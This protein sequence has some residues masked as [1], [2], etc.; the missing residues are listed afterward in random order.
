MR[1][2]R[3]ILVT[4][5]RFLGDIVLSTPLLDALRAAFPAA[6][7]EYLGCPPHV[8][9]LERHPSVDRIHRLAADADPAAMLSMARALRAGR[10]DVAID[11]FGNP[12]SALLVAATGASV[13]VGPERGLRSYL[14]THRRGRPAGDRSA[15]RH[16]LDKIVPVVGRTVESTRPRLF[17]GEEE[18]AALRVRLRIEANDRVRLVHPGSTWPD[19]AWPAS[20]WEPVIRWLHEQSADPV[21]VLEPP[22]QNGLAATVAARTGARPLP[23]L[24]VREVLALLTHTAL[25][26]GNDGGILHAA[27]A[28]GVPTLGLFGPT[29]PDIWFPYAPYGPFRVLH[30]CDADV[31]G[32]MG[33]AASRLRSLEVETVIDGLVEVMR[34]AEVVGDA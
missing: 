32:A 30:R 1:A 23:V 12:R 28:L 13:R 11:L 9:V 20:R 29:E 24:G 19:K 31:P 3:A 8:D 26:V 4:R 34:A 5:L 6:R 33:E 18:R 10:F 16:H 17:V 27:V 2:P 21:F 15:L 22:G 25:Y 7:I 14:Y